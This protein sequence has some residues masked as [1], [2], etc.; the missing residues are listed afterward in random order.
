M[1][2][3]F[4]ESPFQP[5]N[6]LNVQ[7][8]PPG[9]RT[10]L[11]FSESTRPRPFSS[12]SEAMNYLEEESPI[13]TLDAEEEPNGRTP[14][15]RSRNGCLTC[16]T[17]HLKCDEVK[18][19]CTNCTKGGRTCQW[20]MILKFDHKKSSLENRAWYILPIEKDYNAPTGVWRFEDESASIASQYQGG[21]E[22]YGFS[23]SQSDGHS[24][25]SHSSKSSTSL[26]QSHL[27]PQRL[28]PPPSQNYEPL[29]DPLEMRLIKF[30][31]T[32]VANWMDVTNSFRFVGTYNFLAE[33]LI[34][35]SSLPKC[36][37]WLNHP[38][39]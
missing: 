20:G 22:S 23:E 6:G 25:S 18:P 11:S 24:I 37:C 8:S 39:L 12:K 31:H 10:S 3:G 32:D 26:S 14:V 13:D 16:R 21:L 5:L 27:S 36:P 30:Y 29:S 35:H 9:S 34:S 1:P 19:Q 28:S 17:R 33:A 15:K 2:N 38:W 7:L 4:L